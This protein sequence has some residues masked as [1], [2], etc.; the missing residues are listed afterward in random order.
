MTRR[1]HWAAIGAVLLAGCLAALPL[2]AKTL[3]FGSG[4]DPQSLDP[5]A[6]ALL[7]QTRVVSQIYDSLVSR[8]RDFAL[9]RLPCRGSSSSRSVGASSFA[10]A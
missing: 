7:Y 1:V 5:H 3:R 9:E 6:L 10:R 4:F 2:G 8:D